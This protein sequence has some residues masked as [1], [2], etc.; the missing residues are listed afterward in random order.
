METGQDRAH[1]VITE[2]LG[3]TDKGADGW[4]DHTGLW[5][6]GLGLDSL[7]AAELSAMLEDEFGSDPFS[8]GGDLPEKVG[9]I[10]LFYAA[11]R[12]E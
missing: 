2:F 11:V 1:I 4:T 10:V 9:D 8:A 6:D 7:E 12:T 5:G 3:R